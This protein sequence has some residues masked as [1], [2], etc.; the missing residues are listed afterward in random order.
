M[1]VVFRHHQGQA[2]VTVRM[3]I[4]AFGKGDAKA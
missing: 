3:Y 4:D 2:T 1:A